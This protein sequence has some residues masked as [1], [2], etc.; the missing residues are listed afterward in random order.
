VIRHADLGREERALVAAARA[1]R[2]RAYAPYSGFKVGAAVRSRDARVF[3]G[4]NVENASLSAGVCA[5]RVALVQAAA[6]GVRPGQLR[7]LAVYALDAPPAPPC[8][9]CLQCLVEFARDLDVLLANAR[10][11]E[12]WRLS[13]LLPRPFRRFPRRR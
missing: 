3:A 9:I 6:G 2:R 11:V 8:G 10:G 1:A 4:C 13:A 5:E 12:R 7:A